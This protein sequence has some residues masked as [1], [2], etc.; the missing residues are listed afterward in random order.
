VPEF[1]G[2]VFSDP[3]ISL[4]TMKDYSLFTV[5]LIGLGIIGATVALVLFFEKRRYKALKAAG[6][7]LGLI[8]FAKGER[9]NFVPV[10]LMRKKG[11]GIGAGLHG[12]WKGL[13]ILVFDL[14]HP[15]G[16]SVSIQTV[17]VASF[18]DRAF[19]EFAAVE[20][21]ANLYR[22]T[23]DLPLAE[24]APD[25]LRKHWFLYARDGHWPFDAAHAEW[26]CNHRKPAGWFSSGWSYEGRATALY[27]YRRATTAKPKKLAQWL[28]EALMEAQ[29][30]ARR[31]E[32]PP[33]KFT[34]EME[35]ATPEKDLLQVKTTFK[36]KKHFTWT[37]SD[38]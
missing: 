21:S 14:F 24:D 22:P 29:E 12:N 11:R 27:V 15:A 32:T 6:V 10:E 30:F 25:E 5:L 37:S 16:K 31:A 1:P 19:P 8:P 33:G 36:V 20:K 38:R 9:F 3:E 17:V 28:D 7:S 2:G 35:F 4:Q 18:N 13:P 23:V 34:A 26:L